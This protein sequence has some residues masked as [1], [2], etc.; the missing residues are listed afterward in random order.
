LAGRRCKIEEKARPL[1]LASF[2]F[3]EPE[4]R[5]LSMERPKRAKKAR[6]SS[7]GREE[8]ERRAGA[9]G[10]RRAEAMEKRSEGAKKQEEGLPQEKEAEASREARARRAG[11]LL[12]R[13]HGRSGRES[14]GEASRHGEEK[15]GSGEGSGFSSRRSKGD[16]LPIRRSTEA[17][18]EAAKKESEGRSQK[19]SRA[20]HEKK[21]GEKGS[22]RSLLR[23]TIGEPEG[24]ARELLAFV[25]IFHKEG[26]Q[27]RRPRYQQKGA[28]EP[29]PQEARG[30]QKE[31][32]RALRL[33]QGEASEA[34]KGRP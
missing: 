8:R 27:P 5:R 21:S 14:E 16:L 17:E 20:K 23:E 22:D 10:A 26:D 28:S 13:I 3:E 31:R 18:A 7:G 25:T 33:D 30:G 24:E 12:G 6:S 1:P 29:A 4:V 2:A 11:E 15:E 34:Q 19:A 9:G 32:G